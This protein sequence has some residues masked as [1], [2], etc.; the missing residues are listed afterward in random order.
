MKYVKRGQAKG[1]LYYYNRS[2]GTGLPDDP[3]TPEFLARLNKQEN[4][5][6][7]TTQAIQPGSFSDLIC[8][9][10]ASPRFLDLAE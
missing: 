10:I 7:A 8:C 4:L 3:N 6:D 5:F 2:M 1:W 9:H